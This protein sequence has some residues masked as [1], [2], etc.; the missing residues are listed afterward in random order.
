MTP[1]ETTATER[2]ECVR[3]I[4]RYRPSFIPDPPQTPADTF[5]LKVLAMVKENLI[6]EITSEYLRNHRARARERALR[7]LEHGG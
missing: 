2:A 4:R 1:D 7:V 5:A 3:I 6:D